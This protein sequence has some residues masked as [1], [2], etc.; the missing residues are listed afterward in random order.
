MSYQVI[1]PG[2]VYSGKTYSSWAQDWFNW[3]L[4]ADADKHNSGPVAFLRA[5]LMP[6]S[7]TEF[8]SAIA[9]PSNIK[10]DTSIDS[11]YSDEPYYPRKYV[12][13]PNV[14]V[15]ADRLQIYQDQAVFW[16][17]ITAYE[18]ANKPYIDW[19]SMQ[20]TTGLTIDYGDNPPE[21][22]DFTIDGNNIKL[23]TGVEHFR[24][25]TPVFT[26][27]VPDTDYGRSVKDFLEISLPP[28]QYPAMIEGYFLMLKFTKSAIVHSIARAPRERTGPYVAELLYQIEVNVR[29][30]GVR[31]SSRD[32]RAAPFRSARHQGIIT[33]ILSE[34]VEKNELDA[35][36][37]NNLMQY[38]GAGSRIFDEKK[39]K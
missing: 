19:G 4:S 2:E 30:E 3:L 5:N 26:V 28:G 13:N 7:T 6:N 21:A 36:V 25:S 10:D 1:D 39:D 17:I 38:S 27:I 9:T 8:A 31:A 18:I 16:P 22:V 11:A 33:R 14:R 37:A 29:P 23:P 32:K 20:D 12:N 34:K 35:K 15:G 24:I